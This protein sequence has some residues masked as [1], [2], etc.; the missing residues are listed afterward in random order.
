MES[1]YAVVSAGGVESRIRPEKANV[2]HKI[3][4]KH[5]INWV[6][7]AVKEAGASKI[8]V[9]GGQNSE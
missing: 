2:T 7:D 5:M 6:I 1:F 3:G 9:A 8:I 4:G